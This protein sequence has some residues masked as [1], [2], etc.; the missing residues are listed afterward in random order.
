MTTKDMASYG[1]ATLQNMDICI[2]WFS[3]P[4]DQ[5][6]RNLYVSYTQLAKW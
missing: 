3:E 2:I 1:L 5:D 4:T 6:I